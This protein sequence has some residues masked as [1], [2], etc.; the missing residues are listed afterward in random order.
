MKYRVGTLHNMGSG[1]FPAAI[2][3]ILALVGLAIAMSAR[4]PAIYEESERS[5]FEWRGWS[6]IIG[7]T[8]AFV[9][10]GT[11]GGLVLATFAIVFITALGDRKNTLKQAFFL[12]LAMVAVSVILFHWALQFDIPLFSWG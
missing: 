5:N 7:G 8:A 4:S 2:G 11:Y 12:A 10:L 6:C 3:A 9:A 1:L